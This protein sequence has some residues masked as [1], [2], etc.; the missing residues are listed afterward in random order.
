MRLNL[1]AALLLSASLIG[2]T[3]SAQ[4]LPQ[5]PPDYMGRYGGVTQEVCTVL[6]VTPSSAY[7]AG[8][9]VGG[10]IPLANVFLPSNSAVLQ[11]IR[12]TSKS[13]QTAEFDVT[14]FSAQ[15]VASTWTD[16]AAPAIAAGDVPLAQ[17][18]IKLTNNFSGLGT[19]TVYGA[20]NI[21]R[22]VKQ[23]APSVYAVITTPGAPTFASASDLQL[24]TA[25]RLD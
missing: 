1:K 21:N 7:S 3:A 14:L 18:P 10:L 11:S 5:M 2:G 20:D 12:L 8:N 24:C 23:N 6:N 15:P 13:V 4:Q 16:K 19:H 9:V 22:G 25:W 17:P